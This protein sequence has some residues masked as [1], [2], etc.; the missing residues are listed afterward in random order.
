MEKD[1]NLQEVETEV[2]DGS[3][4]AD[5]QS[6]KLLKIEKEKQELLASVAAA[7][8]KTLKSRVAAILNIFP[9]T[10]NSDVSLSL[11]YWQTFQ[12]DLYKE[13][14]IIPK[15]FFK[16]ERLHYIVRARAKIQNEYGLFQADDAIRRHRRQHEEKME[17]EVIHDEAP[18]RVVHVFADETGKNQRFVSVASVWILSGRAVFSISKA[19]TDWQ[20]KSNWA[21]RE[22]HFAKMGRQDFD[23]LKKYLEIVLVNREFISFKAIAVERA[24]TKRSIAE[25]VEKLHEYM[26]IRGAAHE[27]ECN[28]I[29]LPRE[30]EVTLDEEQSLDSFVLAELR[31]RI[32]DAFERDSEGKLTI[33]SIKTT[34]SRI[35][36]LVQ[37]ADLIAG[38]INRKLNHDGERNFKDDM[39]DLVI[40][41]LDL[42]LTEDGIQGLDSSALFKI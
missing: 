36:P 21:D 3:G 38:A 12:P 34:S 37:L 31:T 29:D 26:L 41:M 35:S 19:I 5:V 24:K 25:V 32:T 7:D 6:K 2:Q 39:A 16:L 30:I 42:D 18:R 40:T 14:G 11:K 13:E 10:R 8:F 28:R 17:S 23:T 33:E 1:E 22:V 20:A 9:A 4:A 27:V 15:D